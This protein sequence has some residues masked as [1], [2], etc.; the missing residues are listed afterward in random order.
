MVQGSRF[1]ALFVTTLAPLTLVGAGCIQDLGTDIAN[2]DT[3]SSASTSD[4]ASTASATG[5][6]CGEDPTTG[7][8]LCSG[9]SACS[10]IAVDP[11]ALA[12]CGFRIHSASAVMDLECL[13]GT[14]L[15]PIGVPDTCA[16]ASSLLS[17]LT[18]LVV[19]EGASEGKC[20]QEE[21]AEAGTSTAATTTSTTG[22]C[23]NECLVSCGAATDCQQLCGC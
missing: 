19:C 20:V 21:A 3:S 22:T 18:S 17:G 8:T 23:N 1:L 12:G 5:I 15:C 10:S 14:A 16:E 6:N 11:S 4:D 7:I 13:C 2:T 9:I